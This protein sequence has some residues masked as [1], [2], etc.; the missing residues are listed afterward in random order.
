MPLPITV[1]CSDVVRGVVPVVA[2]G[3]MAAPDFG[4]SVNPILTKEGGGLYPSNNTATPGFSNL[5]TAQR[6]AGPS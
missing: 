4:K 5:P 1:C 6:A 2:G 3:T